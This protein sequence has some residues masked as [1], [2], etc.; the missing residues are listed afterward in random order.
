MVQKSETLS[1]IPLMAGG[2]SDSA[3]SES[4]VLT[5]TTTKIIS[6][7]LE[8]QDLNKLPVVENDGFVVPLPPVEQLSTTPS[9]NK[10]VLNNNRKS[11]VKLDSKSWQGGTTTVVTPTKSENLT[12]LDVPSP[13][14][15]MKTRSST[16]TLPRMTAVVRA[17]LQESPSVAP[18]R[19]ANVK[20][21]PKARP[22]VKAVTNDE[23]LTP[24]DA[25]KLRI[26]RERNKQAAARCRK[27]RMDQI[28]TLS[29]K[30]KEQEAKKRALEHTIAQ[31]KDQMNEFQY[32][33][34]QHQAECNLNIQHQHIPVAVKSEPVI[35]EPLEQLYSSE[36]FEIPNPVVNTPKKQPRRPLSLNIESANAAKISSSVEGVLI[37]T[38]S[39][40][41]TSLGFDA[42]MT[43]TG[44]TP[45][46]TIVTPVSFL[47]TPTCSSQQRISEASH[48]DLNTPSTENI[49][50]V[51][52]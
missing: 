5:P 7:I 51:S 21:T 17:Q 46:T 37:D 29:E 27:R 13:V 20:R 23:D 15:T 22:G 14:S 16:R 1:L 33:L 49:S 47:T 36:R 31:L 45:T 19:Q 28:E 9:G 52:L 43:S 50:L 34:S 11:F 48:A 24:E 42:L 6:Q 40:I 12:F 10:A 44:L 3:A 18:R 32:I 2:V 26:R 38:P 8:S 39:N 41:I 4:A 30:V 35:V 25:E